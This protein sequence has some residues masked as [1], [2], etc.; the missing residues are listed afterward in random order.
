LLVRLTAI[1]AFI[2]LTNTGVLSRLLLL[3]EQERWTTI[4]FF[5]ALWAISVGAILIAALHPRLWQRAF[6]GAL[7]ATATGVAVAYQNVSGTEFGVF[8][9]IS[10]W[11]ARHETHRAVEFYSYEAVLLGIVIL[12]V[13]ALLVTPPV[14][15]DGRATRWIR[16]LGWVPAVP[17]ALIATILVAKEGGGG[18]GLPS[19]FTPLSIGLVSATKI[20]GMTDPERHAIKW[21]PGRPQVRHVVM[22]VD[23]SVRADYIDWRPGNPFTPELA[24]LQNQL[25]NYGPAASAGNCSHYSNALLRFAASQK[26][27]GAETLTNPTLWQYAKRAGYRTVFIDAQSAF[28]RDAGKLQNFMTVKE[29]ADIDKLV[30]MP[31]STPSAELDDR[32]LDVVMEELRSD[33]PVFIYANKNGAHFPY[34]SAYPSANRLFQPTM[35]DTSD[36]HASGSGAIMQARI[37]SYRNAIRWS[38]DRFFKRLFIEAT[39]KDAVILYTSDHGQAFHPHRLTHCSVEEPDPR[40]ALVP[41]FVVTPNSGLRNRF[42]AGAREN[43][44][45]ATHFKLAPT[46]LEL[47]GY[48]KTDIAEAYGPSLFDKNGEPAGFTTGDIFGLFQ[49]K[50]RWHTI[51]LTAPYLEVGPLAVRRDAPN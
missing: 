25:V 44:G 29:T 51:D 35:S 50:P 48:A 39:L 10:L 20:A 37:N 26:R 46:L 15:R 40:E 41:M 3:R 43:R 9:A 6:W 38:V 13:F 5:L 42:A 34:D 32:L 1:V 47:F 27:L 28:N 22:L 11:N 16:R 19:Q 23:E 45:H 30:T 18:Q 24:N 14:L 49:K 36:S 7:I 12:V 8:D 21:T 4:G 31:A 17:I 33:Q 2:A